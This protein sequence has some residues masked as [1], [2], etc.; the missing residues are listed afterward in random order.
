MTKKVHYR[1]DRNVIPLEYDLHLTL[2]ADQLGFH[3]IVEIKVDV[4][5]TCSQIRLH[6]RDLTITRLHIGKLRP[7][8]IPDETLEEVVIELS[9][10]LF[11]G[12]YILD[13]EYSGSVQDGQTGLYKSEYGGDIDLYTDCDYNTRTV[14][15][16]HFATG[17]TLF[18]SYNNKYV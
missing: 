12:I 17:F 4:R 18:H 13:I 9:E 11:P 8:I 3:G 7:E 16:T 10:P 15:T 1:L 14:L 2:N 5:A 6:A